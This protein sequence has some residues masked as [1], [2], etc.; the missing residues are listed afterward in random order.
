M[1][2]NSSPRDLEL[3]SEY[4]DGR[5]D[6]RQRDQLEARL[7]STKE[8]AETLQGL[9]QT[10]TLLRSLPKLKS[11][12]SFRLTPEMVGKPATPRLYPTFQFA[13]IL[14]SLLLVLVL[15]GDILGLGVQTAS[16][17]AVP[18]A[19]P[20]LAV[21]SQDMGSTAEATLVPPSAQQKS[22]AGSRN[23]QPYPAA[24]TAALGAAVT[25]PTENAPAVAA[26]GARDTST[27]PLTETT[28]I[29]PTLENPQAVFVNP[30]AVQLTA[31]QEPVSQT[32]VALE[33]PLAPEAQSLNAAQPVEIPAPAPSLPVLRIIEIVLVVLA[34]GTGLAAFFLRRGLGK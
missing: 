31:T 30:P 17:M 6:A 19:A 21:Q 1:H 29:S 4:L 32:Q 3:L 13:S 25:Q 22:L 14:A 11:P 15:A 2:K 20:P 9:A 24:S 7:R 34:L 18:A 5:L 27:P 16:R 8:L 23:P 28:G 33:N 26:L 12:R 10:R